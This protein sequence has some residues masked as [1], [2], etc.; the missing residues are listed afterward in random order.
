MCHVVVYVV[1]SSHSQLPLTV[2]SPIHLLLLLGLKMKAETNAQY[3]LLVCM[4]DYM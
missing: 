3:A 2:F 4:G 1:P